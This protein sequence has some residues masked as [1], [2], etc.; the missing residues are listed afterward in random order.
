MRASPGAAQVRALSLAARVR[1]LSGLSHGKISIRSSSSSSMI[2]L[3]LLQDI[4]EWM[5]TSLG[6]VFLVAG[7]G[8]KAGG[9]EDL[10]VQKVLTDPQHF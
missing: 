8:F 3:Y 4:P 10:C 9:E 5:T 6:M 2:F 7:I 1:A